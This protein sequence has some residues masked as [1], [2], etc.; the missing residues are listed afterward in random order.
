L[1]W[2]HEEGLALPPDGLPRLLIEPVFNTAHPETTPI[3]H[4]REH[5]V[6]QRTFPETQIIAIPLLDGPTPEQNTYLT[7]QIYLGPGQE[8]PEPIFYLCREE[9]PPLYLE[10]ENSVME[11]SA[12]TPEN[13]TYP[14]KE[15]M[16]Q[17]A[18]SRELPHRALLTLTRLKTRIA[19]G[20]EAG[21]DGLAS[22]GEIITTRTFPLVA[23]APTSPDEIVTVISPPGVW[24]AARFDVDDGFSDEHLATLLETSISLPHDLL[25]T[26]GNLVWNALAQASVTIIDNGQ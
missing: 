5:E 15:V 1:D 22:I 4:I 10:F 3:R 6:S 14:E 13:E 25:L 18:L 20:D 21:R 19:A 17:I 8:R 12:S 7:V 2:I 26:A 11:A 23:D 9:K 24:D 16:M